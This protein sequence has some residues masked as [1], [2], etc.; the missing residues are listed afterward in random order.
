MFDLIK[1][2]FAG[3]SSVFIIGRFVG[4][5]LSNSTGPIKCVLLNNHLCHLL[6]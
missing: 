3:L 1:K 4:S 6:I 5:I 2:N